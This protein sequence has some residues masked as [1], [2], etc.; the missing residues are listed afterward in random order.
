MKAILISPKYLQ[1][2]F[3]RSRKTTSHDGPAAGKENKHSVMFSYKAKAIMEDK[4]ING[5]GKKAILLVTVSLRLT[6]QSP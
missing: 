3:C 1:S 4:K 2:R 5:S 6:S